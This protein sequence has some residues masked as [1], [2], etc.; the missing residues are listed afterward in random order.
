MPELALAGLTEVC[1]CTPVPL[2]AIVAG[3]FVA[4]L[5]TLRLPAALPAVAG[6]KP[7]VSV[8][9]CP[10]ARVTAPVKPLTLNPAP[11]TAACEMVT[12]PVPLFVSVIVCVALL[13]TSALPKLRLLVLAESRYVCA[14]GA[15]DTPVPVTAVEC[16]EVHPS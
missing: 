3:E 10:A 7:T 13:P 15:G 5:T 6:A 12:L 8:K 4:V 11:L 9:L 14:G 1:G 16:V 2:N